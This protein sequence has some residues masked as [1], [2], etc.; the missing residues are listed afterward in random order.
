[1]R[2]KCVPG[3]WR[4]NFSKNDKNNIYLIIQTLLKS[5]CTRIFSCPASLL[6]GWKA[7]LNAIFDFIYKKLTLLIFTIK[8]YSL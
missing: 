2:L 7:V 4:S 5:Y 8:I 3:W 1:M 6:R